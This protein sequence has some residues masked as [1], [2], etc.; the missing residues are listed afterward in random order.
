MEKDYLPSAKYSKEVIESYDVP[1]MYQD[2]CVNEYVSFTKC[3][4]ENPKIIENGLV[5]ALPFS[6]SF[7]KCGMIKQMWRKCQEYRE[8]EIYDEMRKIYLENIKL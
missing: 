5:Y 3:A 8:R 6:T 7:T 1:Y 4:R 2:F